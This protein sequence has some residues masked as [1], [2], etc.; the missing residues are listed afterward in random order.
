MELSDDTIKYIALMMDI[1]DVIS[2]C[3]SSS[4]FNRLICQN[5]N[6]WMNKLVKDFPDIEF[7]LFEIQDYKQ[8]YFEYAYNNILIRILVSGY[9][10]VGTKYEYLYGVGDLTYHRNLNVKYLI[11]NIITDL[12]DRLEY[13]GSYDVI[14]NDD[15]YLCE[16]VDTLEYHCFNGIS[17]DTQLVSVNFSS[18]VAINPNIDL[19]ELLSESIRYIMANYN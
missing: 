18:D 7:N 9:P 10:D 3:T 4:R 5:Q 17:N 1:P 2:L 16:Y 6:Y 8:Y 14:I 19:T 12:F 13:S 15:D 11:Y